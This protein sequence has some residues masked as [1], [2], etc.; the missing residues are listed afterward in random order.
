MIYFVDSSSRAAELTKA[1]LEPLKVEADFQI[2]NQDFMPALQKI[3]NMGVLADFVFL[4]PPYALQEVYNRALKRLSNSSVLKPD[5]LVI[6]EHQKRLDPGEIFAS[7]RRIRKL[8]QGD[9]A[10]SFFRRA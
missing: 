3:E 8:V 5:T 2:L 7:L 9:A 10:L 1:N 4:D 6:A